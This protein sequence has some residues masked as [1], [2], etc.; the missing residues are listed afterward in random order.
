MVLGVW[1]NSF[2]A[3]DLGLES[4]HSGPR[5]EVWSLL[6]PGPGFGFG[7]YSFRA[8]YS[9]LEFSRSAA[10]GSLDQQDLLAPG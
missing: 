8:R 3:R 2:R 6:I 1:V 9:G 4:T 10:R 5:I 7:V